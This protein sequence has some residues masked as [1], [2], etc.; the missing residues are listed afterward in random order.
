ML[1]IGVRPGVCQD[2]MVKLRL[3]PC[4]REGHGP[5]RTSAE[6]HPAFGV[7]RQLHVG[8]LFRARQDLGFHEVGVL[9]RNGVVFHAAFG[10]AILN[11]HG[12]HHGEPV[13][14]NHVVKNGGQVVVHPISIRRNDERRRGAGNIL[15]GNIDA[16]RA[17]ERLVNAGIE[18]ALRRI[19]DELDNFTLGNTG[20]FGLFRRRRI[21]RPDGVIAITRSRKPGR[22][23]WEFGHFRD[24]FGR[25]RD[26]RASSTSAASAPAAGIRTHSRSPVT[27][28]SDAG[29]APVPAQMAPSRTNQSQASF[30]FPP[31]KILYRESSMRIPEVL[32]GSAQSP[33]SGRNAVEKIAAA[34]LAGEG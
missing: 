4:H 12:D 9:R 11:H 34:L 20:A 26:D 10:A 1:Q 25:C 28:T 30:Q 13:V 2:P 7:L 15:G 8:L 21:I 33:S 22:Q 32:T 18:F 16:N 14:G 27:R 29:L 24:V 6:S 17:L 5:A 23:R 19:H 3:E 31:A